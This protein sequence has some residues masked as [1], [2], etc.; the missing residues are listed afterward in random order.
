[1]VSFNF[2]QLEPIEKSTLR[3]FKTGLVGP[4]TIPAD[5]EKK[6]C[7]CR[8]CNHETSVLQFLA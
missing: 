7:L 8:E 1:M 3:P 4:K 6:P 2:Q 5:L